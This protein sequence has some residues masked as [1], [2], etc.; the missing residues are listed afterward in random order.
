MVLTPTHSD[1]DGVIR[2]ERIGLE[3]RRTPVRLR[4]R[5]GAQLACRHLSGGSNDNPVRGRSR[6]AD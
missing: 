6:A 3:R 4:Q 1:C 5:T 2:S